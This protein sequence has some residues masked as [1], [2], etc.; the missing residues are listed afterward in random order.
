MKKDYRIGNWVLVPVPAEVL[1]PAVPMQIDGIEHRGTK[2]VFGN[3]PTEHPATW[4]GQHIKP[5]NLTT[6]HLDS[7]GFEND[8][9]TGTVVKYSKNGLEL[10]FYSFDLT[11]QV[12]NIKN[13]K[14]F[15]KYVHELQNLYFVLTGSELEID[16]SL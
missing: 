2:F 5:I 13:K 1:I 11:F 8:S 9:I 15:L 7:S 16:C 14:I 10:W 4:F 6:K 3:N 12:E